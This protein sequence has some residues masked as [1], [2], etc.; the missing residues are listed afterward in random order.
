MQPDRIQRS[1]HPTLIKVTASWGIDY[2]LIAKYD[3]RW[4]IQQIVWQSPP[5]KTT[6]R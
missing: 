6:S 4:Q 2:L 3:G 5:P 1:V